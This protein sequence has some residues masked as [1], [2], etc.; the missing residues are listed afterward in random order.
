MTCFIEELR[1]SQMK[2]DKEQ[3][4]NIHVEC[5]EE[6]LLLIDITTDDLLLPFNKIEAVFE[7]QSNVLIDRM[8]RFVARQQLP[9][10][11]KLSI[12]YRICCD[13]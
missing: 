1:R 13:L 9:F 3:P 2:F 6:R 10:D 12:T 5:K 4:E 11:S 8:E 7:L